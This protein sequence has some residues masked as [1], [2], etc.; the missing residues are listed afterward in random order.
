M[1]WDDV[2][3]W[4]KDN[5]GGLAGVAGS[6]VLGGPPAAIAA[7]ISLIKQA[8]GKSDPDAAMAELQGNPEAIVKLRELALQSEASIRDHA[9]AM[10]K[11]RYDDIGDARARDAKIVMAT[12]HT[13]ERA[14]LMVAMAA[15]GLIACLVV[16]V[17]FRKEIPPEAL[18]LITTIA[19]IFGLC[20]R[21]AYQFEFGSSRGSKDANETIRAIAKG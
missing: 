11:L 7:G 15:F 16:L 8:T 2:G 10:E 21:D 14:N 12:G 17:F 6:L 13:N 5:A 19:S 3:S 1:N 4:V 9:Y 20:L 18:G